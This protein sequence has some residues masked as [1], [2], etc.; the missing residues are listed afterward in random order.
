[1][2]CIATVGTPQGR[3]EQFLRCQDKFRKDECRRISVTSDDVLQ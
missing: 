2:N 3:A 1:M